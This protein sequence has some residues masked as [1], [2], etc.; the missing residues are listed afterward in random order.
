MGEFFSANMGTIAVGLVVLGIALAIVIKLVRDK[1]K[2][3]CCG[4]DSGGGCPRCGR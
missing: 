2:G 3:K 4:C 1:R